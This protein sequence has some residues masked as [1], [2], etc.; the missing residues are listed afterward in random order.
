MKIGVLGS[1]DVGRR[2]AGGF[3]CRGGDVMIGSREPGSDKLKEWKAQNGPRALTGSF[4]DAAQ[5]GELLVLATLWSGTEHAL[6][7]AGAENCAGKV[8]I[9]ATNPLVFSENG[10]P[11][12]A[13]GWKD[14]AGEQVQRW[15]PK[16]RVVKAFNIVGNN[17]MIKPDFPCG[18][19]TMFIAGEDDEA[20]RMVTGILD[21]WGWEVCDIGGIEGARELEPMCILWVKYAMH[22]GGRDHAF[23]MLH[24]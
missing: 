7:L 19:P 12:L 15:L 4:S 8:V 9:D 16:S 5:F 14:S 2:L 23:K 6:R 18:P 11:S 22:S 17:H 3:I 1:G 10:P 21:G 20:K 24:K 13:L